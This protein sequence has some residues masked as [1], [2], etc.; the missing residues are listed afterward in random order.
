MKNIPVVDV[1]FKRLAVDLIGPIEPASEAEHRYVLTLVEY[2]TKYPEAISSKR[3]DSKTAAE[4]LVDI[5][6]RLGVPKE[7]LSEQEGTHFISSCM[8]EVC[9]YTI[10][11]D[12]SKACYRRC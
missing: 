9:N 5:Y 10:L 3:I 1:P 2:A 6:S 7:F 8:K 11:P 12:S 4:V